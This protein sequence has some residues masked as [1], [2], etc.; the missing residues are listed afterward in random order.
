MCCLHVVLLERYGSVLACK[1][2]VQLLPGDTTTMVIIRSF[3][4]CT[5]DHCVLVGMVCWA[6]WSRRN[7][8][9]WNGANGLAFGVKASAMNLLNDWREARVIDSC[10]S[11]NVAVGSR[12]WTRPPLGWLKINIDAAVFQKGVL[13]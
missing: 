7:N 10:G 11:C 2:L 1:K 9:I 4:G 8:S 12:V 13:G 3:E 6:L 5:R